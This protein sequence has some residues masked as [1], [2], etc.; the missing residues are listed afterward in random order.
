MWIFKELFFF[1]LMLIHGM[2]SG[3]TQRYF[4]ADAGKKRL[5]FRTG[6]SLRMRLSGEDYF[7]L[8]KIT[9][10]QDSTMVLDNKF[11]FKPVEIEAIQVPGRKQKLRIL[12]SLSLYGGL[13]LPVLSSTNALIFGYRPIFTTWSLIGAG[14][15]LTAYGSMMAATHIPKNL[16]N[17]DRKRF[18]I[19][20]I[21]P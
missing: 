12:K 8:R 16:Y 1:V 17:K 14:V 9:E 7:T 5:Y 20:I 11:S 10:I 21:E 18:K 3:V 19:L 13:S 15:L 6:E 2:S 4:A